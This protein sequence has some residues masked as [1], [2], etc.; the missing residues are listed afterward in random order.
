MGKNNIIIPERF[1]FTTT[2]PIRI[3]DIN[4]GNHV[5]NDSVLSLIHEAR[6]KF[7]QHLGLSELEFAG[8]SLIM[9]DVAIDFRSEIVYGDDVEVRVTAGETGKVNFDLIYQLCIIKEGKTKIAANARTGMVCYDY[10]AKK[11]KPIPEIALKL[12]KP[13]TSD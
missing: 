13:E 5:G 7:L 3:T 12:L 9:S 8:V 4:Y 6:V 2:I 11:I 1:S 10:N